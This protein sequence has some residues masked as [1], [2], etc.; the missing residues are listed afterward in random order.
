MAYELDK[1]GKDEPGMAM[2]ESDLGFLAL[3]RNRPEEAVTFLNSALKRHQTLEESSGVSLDLQR[4]SSVYVSLGDLSRAEDYA[5]RALYS[6]L[7]VENLSGAVQDLLILAR[8]HHRKQEDGKARER[9]NHAKA[10]LQDMDR[11]DLARR[12]E[13][14]EEA[15]K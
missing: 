7:A 9:L 4:L 6:H 1:K 12:I 10:L 14:T 5:D 3:Q 2:R 15:L 8:I 13:V 11:E